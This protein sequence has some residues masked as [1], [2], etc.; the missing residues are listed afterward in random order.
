MLSFFFSIAEMLRV[1]LPFDVLDV[2][3]AVYPNNDP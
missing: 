3:R 2:A 1:R